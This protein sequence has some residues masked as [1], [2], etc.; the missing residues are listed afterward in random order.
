[1]KLYPAIDLRNGRCV[2]LYQG[3]YEQETV[4][5]DDPVAQA[6][7]FEAEGAEVVH[8]VDLD[9]ARTGEPTN[10]RVIG[11]ICEAIGVPIQVGGGVR[12]IEAAEALFEAG[13]DRVVIGTAALE[14]PQLVVDVVRAGGRVAVGLDARGDEVS[15]HGWTERTG[16]TV[17]E[18]AARFADSGVEALVVTEI[19]RDGTLEGPDEPGLRALLAA[20]PIPVVASGGVGSLDHIRSLAA[21]THVGADGSIRRLDGVIVGRALYE[22]TFTVAE[23]L[24]AT[25]GPAEA[26]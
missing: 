17:G 21:V 2:R 7:A 24:A 23:A 26:K 14:N 22:R 18:L 25:A 19:S 16:R 5:G 8:V 6:K 9:A 4:Y 11:A 13:V 10:R 20:T 15:T 3:D 12:T 1:M